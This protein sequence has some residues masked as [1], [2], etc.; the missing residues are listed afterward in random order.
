MQ[1]SLM[2]KLNKSKNDLPRQIRRLPKVVQ[3]QAEPQ[4]AQHKKDVEDRRIP[5][6]RAHL[7]IVISI[8]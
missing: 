7:H 1:T 5:L 2:L 4:S 6:V 3:E 8:A